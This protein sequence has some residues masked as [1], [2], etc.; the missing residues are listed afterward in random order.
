MLLYMLRVARCGCW[1][2]LCRTLSLHVQLC[3]VR[4]PS[5]AP[6]RITLSL[7]LYI[8]REKDR[9]TERQRDRET[10]RCFRCM[11]LRGSLSSSLTHAL[12]PTFP[13]PSLS[14]GLTLS[15]AILTK[16]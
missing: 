13:P 3:T 16:G 9:E 10:K 5:A 7:L 15:L 6:E 1:R 2:P 14:F 11:M 12:P 4:R 8:E